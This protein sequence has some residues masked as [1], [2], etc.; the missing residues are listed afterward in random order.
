MNTRVGKW[1]NSMGIRIPSGFA[2]DLGIE[3]DTEVEIL[4]KDGS[5]TIT[6]VKRELSLDELVSQITPENLH[7]E[8]DTG[9]PAGNEAW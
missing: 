3:F 2:R 7:H 4:E 8:I 6:P 5:L 1:G 9:N